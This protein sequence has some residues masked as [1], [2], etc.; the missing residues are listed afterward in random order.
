[1]E[2]L[3]VNTDSV[4]IRVMPISTGAPPYYT[5]PFRGVVGFY[6]GKIYGYGSWADDAWFPFAMSRNIYFR[7]A[8][9]P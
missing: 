7:G 9:T 4:E 1:M 8:P 3:H 6:A 2:R 5:P